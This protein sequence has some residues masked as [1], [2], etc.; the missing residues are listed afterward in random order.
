MAMDRKELPRDINF[1]QSGKEDMAAQLAQATELKGRAA[2]V[3]TWVPEVDR[4]NQEQRRLLTDLTKG[5]TEIGEELYYP[6]KIQDPASIGLPRGDKT[7]RG[8]KLPKNS[9][10]IGQMLH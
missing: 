3:G 4:L 10:L 1:R 6:A 7:A 8:F 5:D 9:Q 2:E